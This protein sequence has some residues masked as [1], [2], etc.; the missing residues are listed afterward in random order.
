MYSKYYF[1]FRKEVMPMSFLQMS[2][3]GSILICVIVVVRAVAINELPKKTFIILWAVA[4]LRLL[5]PISIPSVFSIYSLANYSIH[6]DTIVE[7]LPDGT[8]PILLQSQSEVSYHNARFPVWLIVWG[9]GAVLCAIFFGVAYVRCLSKFH[10]ALP[11]YNEFVEQWQKVQPL[12]RHLSIRQSEYISAPLTYGIFRPV[13]LL[14]KNTDWDN[15]QQLQ[16]ILL[17]EYTHIRHYDLVF[18]LFAVVALCIHWFNPMVWVLYILL[19]R[20]IELAC[21]EC[22]VRNLGGNM[23]ATYALTLITMEE[24]K[25]GL[26]PLCNG[27]SKNAIEERIT[28][29][30][31]MRKITIGALM[32]SA[33]LLIVIVALFGTSADK[34]SAINAGDS[35]EILENS[36]KESLLAETGKVH[37]DA[38][39]MRE[40]P[41]QDASV[42]T[43]LKE[44]EKV[45]ILSER[46]GFYE[47][48]I[49][50]GAEAENEIM[51]GWVKKEYIA[52]DNFEY[53]VF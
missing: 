51:M 5:F 13:I 14:P 7:R 46:D 52:L 16:Y 48:Q 23:K 35:Q 38:L 33:G 44:G 37:V 47:V 15:E 43:L 27:F 4:L 11:V 2:I 34:V 29:I 17:H 3:S 39:R 18:K 40:E 41:K 9:I 12:K 24:K 6:H 28:A 1:D 10:A 49:Q 8:I 53:Y 22:V 50:M 32:A 42:V 31:K 45:S 19:N 21:D 20:D 25:S 36:E 26:T 30:M